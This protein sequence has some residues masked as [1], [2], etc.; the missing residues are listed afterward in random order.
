MN[1][2]SSINPDNIY[3]NLIKQ[4]IS[5]EE[6][7][8]QLIALVEESIDSKIRVKCLEIFAHINFKIDK[9]FKLLETCLISDDN[10]FVRA[11]AAKTIAFIFPKKGV[12]PLKW[13]LHH[14]TSPLVVKTISILFEGIDDVY[15]K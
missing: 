14:E 6:A 15:F 12:E 11:T 3:S 1:N 2:F 13:A 4:K 8:I 10:E 7:I 9:V 5:K